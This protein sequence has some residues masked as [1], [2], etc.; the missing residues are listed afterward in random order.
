M[1]TSA[2]TRTNKLLTIWRNALGRGGRSGRTSTTKC[3]PSRTPIIAPSM[4]IQM[5]RNR[6]SS[7]VQIHEGMSAV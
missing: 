1:N 3:D 4:I 7:S 5:N 2:N 6:D